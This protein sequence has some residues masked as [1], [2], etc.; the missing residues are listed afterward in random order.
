MHL[1]ILGHTS[2]GALLYFSLYAVY[3]I[4][5]GIEFSISFIGSST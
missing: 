4:S 5:G 2:A 1:E 3:A